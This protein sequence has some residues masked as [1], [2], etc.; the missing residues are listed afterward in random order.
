[1][2]VRRLGERGVGLCDSRHMDRKSTALLDDP[3]S[4][5]I[6]YDLSQSCAKGDMNRLVID[7]LPQNSIL[8]Q[9][10][11][12]TLAALLGRATERKVARGRPLYQQGDAGDSMAVVLSGIF[13]VYVVT[14]RGR[15]VVIGFISQGGA[16]GEIALFDAGKRTATVEATET[17]QV[18]ILQ[19]SDVRAAIARDGAAA[20]R[21]IDLLCR[22]LRNTNMRVEDD[23]A[24]ALEPRLAR[25]LLRVVDELENAGDVSERPLVPLRQSDLAAYALLSRENVN[26]QLQKWADEGVVSLSRGNIRVLDLDALAQLAEDAE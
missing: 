17:S 18:L 1:M 25:A 3:M 10:S 12:E 14:A 11:K 23:A 4:N 26:R 7:K 5:G 21:V 13:K 19:A 9:F 24:S 20:L 2:D 16:I 15:E 6:Q 8:R 22:R